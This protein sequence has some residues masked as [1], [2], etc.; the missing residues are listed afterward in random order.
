LEVL[1]LLFK[2]Y[3][4]R[5]KLIYIS[6]LRPERFEADVARLRKYVLSY[7]FLTDHITEDQY[8]TLMNHATVAEQEERKASSQA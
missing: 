1:K 4:G 5:I 7:K 3:F 2:P 6:I 8:R